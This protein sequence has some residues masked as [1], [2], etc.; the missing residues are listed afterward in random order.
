MYRL[1][2]RREDLHGYLA[3]E[4]FFG[5]A[6][7]IQLPILD[8]QLPVVRPRE[9]LRLAKSQREVNRLQ[10]TVAGGRDITDDLEVEVQTLRKARDLHTRLGPRDLVPATV[11]IEGRNVER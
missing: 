6:R 1:R 10:G 9:K 11:Q 4:R 7:H 5:V 8:V 3:R 2:T